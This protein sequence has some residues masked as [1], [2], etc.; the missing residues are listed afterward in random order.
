VEDRERVLVAEQRFDDAS[1][2]AVFDD[3]HRVENGLR[4]A[5]TPRAFAARHQIEHTGD[6]AEVL[7]ARLP[8]VLVVGDDEQFERAFI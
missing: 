3:A 7:V 1:H 4:H 5:R 2:F 6:V 8:R